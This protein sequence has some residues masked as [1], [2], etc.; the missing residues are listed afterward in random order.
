MGPQFRRN[1]GNDQISE[2]P[3]EAGFHG[4]MF[5][6]LGRLQ[7]SHHIAAPIAT[8]FR[9]TV[10]LGLAPASAWR[11]GWIETYGRAGCG[12]LGKPAT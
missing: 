10:T 5:A 7:A 8:P 11:I 4:G 9:G 6:N 1:V 12:R 2:S 3:R